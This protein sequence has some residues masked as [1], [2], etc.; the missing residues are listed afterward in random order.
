[1]ALSR[2]WMRLGSISMRQCAS[3]TCYKEKI[4]SFRSLS[5][6]SLKHLDI[7]VND[8]TGISVFTMKR[9]PANSL[10]LS[11]LTEF[12]IALEKLENDKRCKGLIITSGVPRF[13]SAGVEFTELF[14][15]KKD[16]LRAF[17]HTLQDFWLKLYGSRI[18]TVAAING[19]A[20]AGGCLIAISCDYRL[21][22]SGNYTIGLNEAL[23]GFPAP[24]W[25]IDTMV[26]TV[27]VKSAERAL[28]LGAM[29]SSNEALAL[30]L[31]DQVV[32][33]ADLMDAAHREITKCMGV[34]DYA[35]Q[36]T[37]ETLRKPTLKRLIGKETEAMDI[38]TEFI[39][40]VDCQSKM[41]QYLKERKEKK[42]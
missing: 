10:D 11:M 16:N 4:I 2:I 40:S 33:E 25:L 3:L 27:G 32:S 8:V 42:K 31:V 9:T 37:K 17:W 21:M 30:G 35:R 28:Q 24:F 22:A 38:S 14:K 39:L 13:F 20:P 12:N 15:P 5:G 26:N 41:E 19:H 36:L 1:M 7:S 6:V 23:L 34:P 18:V 29:Y